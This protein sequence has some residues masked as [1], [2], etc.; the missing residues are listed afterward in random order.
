MSGDFNCEGIK[1]GDYNFD[2]GKYFFT[3]DIFRLII[4]IYIIISL[5]L[6]LLYLITSLKTKFVKEIHKINLTLMRNILF[7]NFLHTFSYLFEWVLQNVENKKSL[8]IDKDDPSNKDSYCKNYNDDK[9]HF[10]IGG[11]LIGNMNSMAACKT[12]GFFL[13]FSALSQD[14]VIIIFFYLV[15]KSSRLSQVK[16]YILLFIGYF[17]SFIIT[18]IYLVLDG[19]GL[20]DKYCFIKKFNFKDKT[21]E[22]NSK[23]I[24]MIITYYVIRLIFLIISSCLLY[25]ISKYIKENK[26]GN[27]YIIR[28]ASFLI[29]QIFTITFGIMY[30]IGSLFSEKFSRDFVNIFLIVNT[31]DGI[32]FPLVSY[33]SNNMY[34]NLCSSNSNE[35]FHID[36]LSDDPDITTNNITLNN[37]AKNSDKSGISTQKVDNN[38][39]VSY[40]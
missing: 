40:I 31:L 34:K 4:I 29:V 32:I 15:N 8:Y 10:A 23:F 6:N 3:A 18:I 38:F 37:Q 17:C 11:L 39:E 5:I 36:F 28:L 21:Y 33:F 7:I 19:F 9:K 30:R 24:A 14:I 22:L 12:Q 25:K 27:T 16:V 1:N 26:L 13:V 35:D 20:N 2:V